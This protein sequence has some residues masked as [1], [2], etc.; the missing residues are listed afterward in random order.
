MRESRSYDFARGAHSNMR[1]VR[2]PHFVVPER[3][4]GAPD[5]GPTGLE[6]PPLHRRWRLIFETATPADPDCYTY[7]KASLSDFGK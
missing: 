6:E 7:F 5:I 4:W 2:D 1:P 3:V